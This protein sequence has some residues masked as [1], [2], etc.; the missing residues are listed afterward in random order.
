M[1][2]NPK[3]IETIS[4]AGKSPDY[5]LVFSSIIPPTKE[6]AL[7]LTLLTND[8]V[9][10]RVYSD[11]SGYEGG[12][13]ASACLYINDHLARSLRFYLGTSQEHTVYEVEGVGLILGLHLLHSLTRQL[14]H[15]TILGTNSQAVIRALSNQCPHSG[16]YLLDTI[17]LAAEQLHAKQDS[18]INRAKHNQVLKAERCGKVIRGG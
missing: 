2:L 11:G 7:P 17:H 6:V 10:V 18:I 15:P 1:G 9:P 14:T 5:N 8:T 3:D 16:H 13:G 4:P 12:I